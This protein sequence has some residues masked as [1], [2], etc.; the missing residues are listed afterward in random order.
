MPWLG[1]VTVGSSTNPADVALMRVKHWETS[2]VALPGFSGSC[3]PPAVQFVWALAY[4][5]TH[6]RVRFDPQL[7]A[8]SANSSHAEKAFTPRAFGATFWVCL[9]IWT[10]CAVAG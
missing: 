6:W 1:L 8:A 4:E 3:R 7:F 2:P 9:T 5:R 10:N